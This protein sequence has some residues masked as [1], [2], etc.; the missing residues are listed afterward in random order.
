MF[1]KT[2]T[3]LSVKAVGVICSSESGGNSEMRAPQSH[4]LFVIHVLFFFS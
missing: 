4:K 2:K 3:W 1:E